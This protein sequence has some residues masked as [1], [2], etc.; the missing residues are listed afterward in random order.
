MRL[1][2]GAGKEAEEGYINVDIRE[3]PNIDIV[4]N[5]MD[6]KF[7]ANYFSEI[8]A[9]DLLEHLTFVECKRLLRR[10]FYWLEPN[11]ILIIQIPNLDFLLNLVLETG[12]H[13]GMR[14]IYGSDGEGETNHPFGFHKWGYTEKSIKHILVSIGFTVLSLKEWCARFA[15]RIICV[16]R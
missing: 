4:S 6:V 10:C 9:I 13:E 12:E 16:K 7:P 15:Y 3:L 5:V 11:G 2:L 14:W 1:K 8:K